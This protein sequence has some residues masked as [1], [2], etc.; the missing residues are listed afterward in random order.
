MERDPRHPPKHPPPLILI[1]CVDAE[2]GTPY[3]EDTGTLGGEPAMAYAGVETVDAENAE[4]EARAGLA[5]DDLANANAIANIAEVDANAGA[6]AGTSYQGAC[7][8]RIGTVEASLISEGTENL[9][10]R[11][12]GGQQVGEKFVSEKIVTPN[13]TKGPPQ[14][15]LTHPLD[16]SMVKLFPKNGFFN[17]KSTLGGN[18]EGKTHFQGEG[19]EPSE[20]QVQNG[21]VEPFFDDQT[22]IN[23]LPLNTSPKRNSIISQKT[24]ESPKR[25]PKRKRE[26]REKCENVAKCVKNEMNDRG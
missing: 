15:C 8:L 18:G 2:T 16:T 20:P 19:C 11:R 23:P 22:P 13:L 17:A 10:D 1:T 9:A 26:D 14:N 12:G 4:T 24:Q 5:S 7:A 25:T 3:S 21:M 6:M